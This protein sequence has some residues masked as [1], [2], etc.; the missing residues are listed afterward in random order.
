MV[1][2]EPDSPAA[3]LFP[4]EDPEREAV[5]ERLS[6]PADPEQGPGKWT[7]GQA[8]QHCPELAG[9]RSPS[10]VW[11]RL[12]AWKISWKCS[13][14]HLVSPDPEYESKQ[15]AILAIRAEAAAQP[16]V[17]RVLYADEA[18][19]YRT[20]EKGRT[21]GK[22]AG[23]GKAQPKPTHTPGANTKRRIIST[24]DT[25]DGRVVSHTAKALGVRAIGTFLRKLRKAYGPMVRLVLVW[26]NWP[27]HHHE[28]VLEVARQQRVE[29]LY[30]PTYAPWTNPIEKLW[31]MLREEVLHLHRLSDRWMELR[32]RV[33]AYLAALNRPNP[34]L[35]RYVGLAPRLPV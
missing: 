11:R 6:R 21:W 26:D 25:A 34:E 1:R 8:L 20:P 4:P 14:L 9:L 31:K 29:L 2:C 13:R 22:K 19:F 5:A 23:G 35:L 10:G 7:L 27:V 30:I 15:A 3:G 12:K 17:L 33:D 16:E 18:S 28:A 32:N 24:L